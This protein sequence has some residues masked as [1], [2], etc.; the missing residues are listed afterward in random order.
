MVKVAVWEI[1]VVSACKAEER[2][3]EP[4]PATCATKPCTKQTSQR[5]HPRQVC[6]HP[7]IR[8]H[9]YWL[10]VRNRRPTP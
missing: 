1:N 7:H 8:G 9:S 5:C 10:A 6:L 3:I 4:R 2:I